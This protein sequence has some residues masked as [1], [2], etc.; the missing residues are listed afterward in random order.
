MQRCTS[1]GR[2]RFATRA[3]LS[4][5][6]R[7]GRKSRPTRLHPT[8]YSRAQAPRLA[9]HLA[10]STIPCE[11]CM[12]DHHQ[13]S[14]RTV[15]CESWGV[16][17]VP[18]IL[19]WAALRCFLPRRCRQEYH[20]PYRKNHKQGFFE[21]SDDID[22]GVYTDN[23]VWQDALLHDG[24]DRRPLAS[25][26]PPQSDAQTIRP[27]RQRT[28][29]ET[30]PANNKAIISCEECAI[31]ESSGP[32]IPELQV[33]SKTPSS[34]QAD[35]ADEKHKITLEDPEDFGAFGD[36]IV[37]EH[38]LHETAT[39]QEIIAA[40]QSPGIGVCSNDNAELGQAA[41]ISPAEDDDKS[42]MASQAQRAKQLNVP[43]SVW[44]EIAKLPASDREIF[45]ETESA[46]PT[47]G[48]AASSSK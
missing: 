16:S 31:D 7:Q 12:G 39:T 34:P 26:I 28:L 37:D 46:P 47:S 17:P 27:K 9:I 29:A 18:G 3:R 45:L 44:Y 19:S 41:E 1:V 43:P 48:G 2:Q 40:V 38:V 8:H 30:P 33:R 10:T 36:T 14:A 22:A 20:V 6:F 24:S 25:A 5:P 15:P 23:V 21:A 32:S 11:T 4:G 35:N 42:V 13:Q